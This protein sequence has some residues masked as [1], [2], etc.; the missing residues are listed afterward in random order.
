MIFRLLVYSRSY[1]FLDFRLLMQ[2]K[3]I[4]LILGGKKIDWLIDWTEF[5]RDPCFFMICRLFTEMDESVQ[6]EKWL[7]LCMQGN[8]D[9]FRTDLLFLT[10]F[11]IWTE[12]FI[13]TLMTTTTIMMMIMN[14]THYPT[15]YFALCTV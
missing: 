15:R 6:L 13:T 1:V 9:H 3:I 12:F 5:G 7:C 2:L 14:V 4:F 11:Y 10:I 8:A